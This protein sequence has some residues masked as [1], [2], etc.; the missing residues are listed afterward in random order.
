MYFVGFA[1]DT[2]PSDPNSDSLDILS[3]CSCE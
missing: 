3:F 2:A 1:I